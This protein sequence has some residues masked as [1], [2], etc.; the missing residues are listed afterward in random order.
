MF[1]IGVLG[2][3]VCVGVVAGLIPVYVS[4]YRAHG[5]A[6]AAATAFHE[7]GEPAPCEVMAKTR[8]ELSAVNETTARVLFACLIGI[9]FAQLLRL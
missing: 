3:A 9:V 6:V 8:T 1:W 7:R 4:H 5:R 2:V